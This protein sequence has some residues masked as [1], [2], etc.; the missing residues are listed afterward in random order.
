M[1]SSDLKADLTIARLYADL[2][3]SPQVAD[4][5]H[6]RIAEEFTQTVQAVLHMT[7]QKDLLESMPILQRSIQQRNPYVDPLSFVQLVLLERLRQGAEPQADY[8][9]GVL[10]SISGIASGLKNTG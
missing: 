4:Q 7:G 3:A 6:G 10:E 8:L 2:V 1:C 9:T 5:I